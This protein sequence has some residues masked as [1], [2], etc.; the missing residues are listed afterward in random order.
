MNNHDNVQQGEPSVES[1]ESQ[2]VRLKAERDYW[3][4]RAQR[5]TD[6]KPETVMTSENKALRQRAEIAESIKAHSDY[7]ATE[8]L[9]REENEAL[10]ADAAVMGRV[11]EYVMDHNDTLQ[12]SPGHF[13][14]LTTLAREAQR[15][16]PGRALLDRLK[17]LERMREAAEDVTDSDGSSLDL[18]LFALTEALA[19]CEDGGRKDGAVEEGE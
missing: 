8:A 9:L 2:I 10:R 12:N 17:A 11:A 18:N 13:S 4:E 15:D 16:K 7:E 1:F 14:E 6:K 5:V 19:A 3:L